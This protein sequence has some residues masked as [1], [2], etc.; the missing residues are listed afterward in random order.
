MEAKLASLEEKYAALD[1]SFQEL[2]EKISVRDG[3]AEG[4]DE[5]DESGSCLLM[6]SSHD[7]IRLKQA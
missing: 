5:V 6:I 4:K 3:K 2:A 7:K 1:R